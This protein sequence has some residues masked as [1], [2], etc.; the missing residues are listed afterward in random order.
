MLKV[1][2]GKENHSSKNN[3]LHCICNI[4]PENIKQAYDCKTYEIESFGTVEFVISIH[5]CMFYK[6]KIS[7]VVLKEKPHE[8]IRAAELDKYKSLNL[9]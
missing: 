1:L 5:H 8:R 2:I 7:E 9:V 3:L 4:L 6:D